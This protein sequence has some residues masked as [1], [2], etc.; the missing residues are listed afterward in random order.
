MYSE[1]FLSLLK[2][3]HGR[4]PA[5]LKFGVL[6]IRYVPPQGSVHLPSSGIGSGEGQ[7]PP[8]WVDE[9]QIVQKLMFHALLFAKFAHLKPLNSGSTPPP[10]PSSKVLRKEM[11]AYINALTNYP[12]MI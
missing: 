2:S 6:E 10:P 4:L 11:P 3:V 9:K 7:K 8:K 12:S 1:Y 5:R